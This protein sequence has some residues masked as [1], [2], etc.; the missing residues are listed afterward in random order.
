MGQAVFLAKSVGRL[1]RNV[2]DN[3]YGRTGDAAR[4][5]TYVGMIKYSENVILSIAEYRL[6]YRD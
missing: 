2:L 5:A 6:E 1:I 4:R 3:A